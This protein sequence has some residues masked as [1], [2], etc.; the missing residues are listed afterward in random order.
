MG[1][2]LEPTENDRFRFS[3]LGGSHP[4]IDVG[5]TAERGGDP[6][7]PNRQVA[8]FRPDLSVARV[9]MERVS[10][11]LEAGEPVEQVFR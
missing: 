6:C 10:A 2:G 4:G 8:Q 9:T 7:D 1:F 3:H 5:H 11:M